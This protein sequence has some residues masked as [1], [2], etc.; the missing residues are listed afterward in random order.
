MGRSKAGKIAVSRPEC[1][2]LVVVATRMRGVDSQPYTPTHSGNAASHS[3]RPTPLH[4]IN[5]PTDR[6]IM[7][8]IALEYSAKTVGQANELDAST[9]GVAGVYDVATIEG[10]ARSLGNSKT[11]FWCLR[12]LQR[13]RAGRLRIARSASRLVGQNSGEGLPQSGLSTRRD[14]RLFS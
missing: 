1:S 7:W 8:N 10:F 12:L 9:T 13:G 5:D 11:H 4:A 14:H 6:N 2:T 3:A